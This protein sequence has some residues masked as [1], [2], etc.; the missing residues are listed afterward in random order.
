MLF[1]LESSSFSY[2]LFL[3][4]ALFLFLSRNLILF[5]FLWSS[6]YFSQRTINIVRNIIVCGTIIFALITSA[7]SIILNLESFTSLLLIFLFLNLRFY[8]H[9]YIHILFT[10]SAFINLASLIFP[11]S[12]SLLSLLLLLIFLTVP[13][14][15]IYLLFYSTVAPPSLSPSPPLF[16]C[17]HRVVLSTFSYLAHFVHQTLQTSLCTRFAGTLSPIKGSPFTLDSALIS[18]SYHF[19]V[20]SS[21]DFRLHFYPRLH[22]LSFLF[23]LFFLSSSPSFS[24]TFAMLSPRSPVLHLRLSPRALIWPPGVQL[25]ASFLLQFFRCISA[26]GRDGERILINLRA[27]RRSIFRFFPPRNVA[28]HSSLFSRVSSRPDNILVLFIAS[29]TAVC[30][31]LCAISM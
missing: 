10:V 28:A 14:F 26:D 22:L 3:S 13:D 18:F 9:S 27:T 4:N 21:T 6:L 20:N 15:A 1:P 2:N 16:L 23:S 29:R 19:L 7:S 12:F 17:R 30:P 11:F 5:D 31:D 8:I 25:L 24:T